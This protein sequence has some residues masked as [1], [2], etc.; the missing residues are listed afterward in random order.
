VH[1]VAGSQA[2]FVRL[3]TVMGR[4]DLL[5]HPDSASQEARVKHVDAVEQITAAWVASH[6][7]DEIVGL[8]GQAGVP[9]AR[10]A[11]IA[12][13]AHN[14]QLRHRGRIVNVGHPRAGPLPTVGPVIGLSE[15]PAAIRRPAPRLGEHTDEVLRDWLDLPPQRIAALRA[16]GV[17]T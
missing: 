12:E 16:G 14:P 17:V 11:S 2:L 9:A 1:V 7:A 5:E 4:P 8:L 3:A 6:T 15:S 10:V 13:V